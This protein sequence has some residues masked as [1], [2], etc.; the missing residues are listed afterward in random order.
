MRAVYSIEN[1]GRL[2]V[3][4]ERTNV[5]GVN[6]GEDAY[7]LP[8]QLTD[9]YSIGTTWVARASFE[10]RFGNNTQASISYTGR[11]QPQDGRLFN[12]GTAEIRAYF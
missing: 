7:S 1:S 12:I 9:G 10:Y 6:V 4:I 3:D 5:A 8:Y 11:V 2:R